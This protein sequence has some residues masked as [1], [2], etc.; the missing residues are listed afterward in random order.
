[1][2]WRALWTET[3]PIATFR[4]SFFLVLFRNLDLRCHTLSPV[5]LVLFPKAYSIPCI[6][7]HVQ[8]RRIYSVSH[9]VPRRVFK[10]GVELPIW[11][12]IRRPPVGFRV[13]FRVGLRGRRVGF[14]GIWWCPRIRAGSE[15]FSQYSVS[16]MLVDT[17]S[18]FLLAIQNA[19]YS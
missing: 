12:P 15:F 3:K 16:S 11:I 2:G 8:K 17:L 1:M 19:A 5:L 18:Q 6:C 14:S 4:L 10:I 13:R 7:V 9:S